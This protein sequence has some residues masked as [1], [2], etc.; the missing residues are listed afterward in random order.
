VSGAVGMAALRSRLAMPASRGAR[1]ERTDMMS[2]GCG[3]VV[4]LTNK[5]C[6]SVALQGALIAM[7]QVHTHTAPSAR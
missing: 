4:R 6:L 1:S 2:V 5:C 7:A 3:L